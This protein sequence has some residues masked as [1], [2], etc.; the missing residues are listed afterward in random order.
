MQAIIQIILLFSGDED[1]NREVN[2]N[3]ITDIPCSWAFIC[4]YI[5]IKYIFTEKPKRTTETK[6]QDREE[7]HVDLISALTEFTFLEQ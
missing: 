1:I 6:E 4:I 7:K 5:Y 2:M 3:I